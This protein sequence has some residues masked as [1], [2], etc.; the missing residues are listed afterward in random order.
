M[1]TN[2][3]L[4]LESLNYIAFEN[5]RGL[6]LEEL[7]MAMQNS[8]IDEDNSYASGRS[9]KLQESILD[10]PFHMSQQ[11]KEEY[12]L[13][14]QKNLKIIEAMDKPDKKEAQ[15]ICGCEA[16]CAIF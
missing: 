11:K 15:R 4:Y 10:D 2:F 1:L 7:N 5:D 6:I 3:D 13:L 9:K 14:K 8:M 12:E 16:F